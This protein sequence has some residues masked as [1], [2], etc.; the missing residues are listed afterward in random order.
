MEVTKILTKQETKRRPIIAPAIA[1]RLSKTQ[2]GGVILL[3]PK[4]FNPKNRNFFPKTSKDFAKKI[5]PLLVNILYKTEKPKTGIFLEQL[6]LQLDYG[7]KQKI[8]LNGHFNTNYFNLNERNKID[9]ILVPYGISI[10]NK[11]LT[12]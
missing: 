10:V 11:T 3:I 9:T 5:P 4:I 12:G 6:A 7:T 1:V 8:L 2:G